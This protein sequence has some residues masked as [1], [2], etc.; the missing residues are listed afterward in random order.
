MPTNDRCD[1]CR[2]GE[3]VW[4]LETPE[5]HLT[6]N[7]RVCDDCVQRGLEAI[8]TSVELRIRNNTY[9]YRLM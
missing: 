1:C 9:P 7:L 6:H 8:R 2:R 4:K 3:R 5:D